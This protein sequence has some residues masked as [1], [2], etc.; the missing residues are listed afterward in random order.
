MKRIISNITDNEST[1]PVFG[2]KGNPPF[3]DPNDLHAHVW[4]KGKLAIEENPKVPTYSKS[5]LSI[6]SCVYC[7][8]CHTIKDSFQSCIGDN[9]DIVEDI[10]T[11][12]SSQKGESY[13]LINSGAAP[14]TEIIIRDIDIYETGLER[15]S[16]QDNIPS[17]L[18]HSHEGI[19]DD[20]VV[21][22]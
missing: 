22:E 16:E 5:K 17:C 8:I 9:K 13:K 14:Y 1:K 7:K 20:Y 15:V 6:R 19:F 3:Y 2:S 21:V 10:I 18:F 11:V 12:K 4:K